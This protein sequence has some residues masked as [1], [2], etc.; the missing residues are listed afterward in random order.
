MVERAHQT[1]HNLIRSK[2][3]RDINDLDEHFKWQGILS[4]V[5][6]AMRA[7]VHTTL[8]ATPSQ[9]VFQRDAIHNIGFQADWQYIK[10]RKQ[11]LIIQNNVREKAT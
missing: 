7:T 8:N 1:L 5:A 4:A 6:F 2:R 3:V 11:K 10:S 9:L